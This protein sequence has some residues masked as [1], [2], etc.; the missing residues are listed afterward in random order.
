MCFLEGRNQSL[1]DC[2]ENF[3]S[4]KCSLFF[5][6]LLLNV[7][8]LSC[9]IK[10]RPRLWISGGSIRTSCHITEAAVVRWEY[11]IIQAVG[12]WSLV[13]CSAYCVCSPVHSGKH[14]KLY[15]VSNWQYPFVS[16]FWLVIGSELLQSIPVLSNIIN[17]FPRKIGI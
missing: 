17:T 2:L 4:M 5:V 6:S 8:L 9:K 14:C 16:Y 13:C 15:S 1:K 3:W 10:L 12:H 11:C 7:D